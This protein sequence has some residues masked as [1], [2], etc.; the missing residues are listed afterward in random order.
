MDARPAP[1]QRQR[2]QRQKGGNEDR[3]KKKVLGEM[4]EIPPYLV[5]KY[6]LCGET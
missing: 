5:N 6:E 4:N 2:Y 1:A 3:R